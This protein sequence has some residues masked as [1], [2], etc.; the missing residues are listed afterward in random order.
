MSSYSAALE[1]SNGKLTTDYTGI[2]LRSLQL[3]ESDATEQCFLLMKLLYPLGSIQAAAFNIKSDSRS[4]VAR[5]LEILDNTVDISC[6]RSLIDILDQKSYEEKLNSLSEMIVYQPMAPSDRLRH[7]LDFR[8][9]L[10]DWALACCLQMARVARWS[11][12]AEQT[13]VCLRH[14]TGFVR[15]AALA[16]LRMASQRALVELLPNLRND[17]DPLVAAQVEQMIVEFGIG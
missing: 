7:L 4:N 9:F 11:L 5:G 6:K 1:E 17:P 3:L 8:H 10:S 14:P 13:L 2:F 16:Y 12:T 15:E